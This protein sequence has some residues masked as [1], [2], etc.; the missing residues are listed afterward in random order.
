MKRV[1][2][3]VLLV[4]LFV[5]AA[6]VP[7][8][9]VVPHVPVPSTDGSLVD[10]AGVFAKWDSHHDES[11]YLDILVEFEECMYHSTS[12]A[13]ALGF[14]DQEIAAKTIYTVGLLKAVASQERHEKYLEGELEQFH[15]EGLGVNERLSHQNLIWAVD[16][17]KEG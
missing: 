15:E 8:Q 4:S 2:L 10:L 16:F 17:C 5:M 6:C 9:P 14:T 12:E 3:T 13:K 11:E 1:G 7:I